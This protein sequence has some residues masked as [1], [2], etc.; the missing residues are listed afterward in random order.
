MEKWE[1]EELD[2]S[3]VVSSQ[4]K[5]FALKQEG[6][7]QQ[8]ELQKSVKVEKV[9]QRWIEGEVVLE[10]TELRVRGKDWRTWCI[11]GGEEEVANWVKER[12][13][14]FAGGLVMG[15]PQWVCYICEE[16]DSMNSQRNPQI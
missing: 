4:G 7:E 12:G 10:Q 8:L 9:R 3:F 2:G 11:E 6:G 16:D 14:I 15:Y 13:S 1:K 5:V